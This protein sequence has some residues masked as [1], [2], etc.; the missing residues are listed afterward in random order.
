MSEIDETGF[1]SIRGDILKGLLAGGAAGLGPELREIL[2][3]SIQNPIVTCF[4]DDDI[5]EHPLVIRIPIED[6][7]DFLAWVRANDP[8]DLPLFIRVEDVFDEEISD[9]FGE[10]LKERG[11]PLA[12]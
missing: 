1:F 12:G 8:F 11:K 6:Q 5:T 10:Y 9:L 3:T 4:C 7:S 2:F